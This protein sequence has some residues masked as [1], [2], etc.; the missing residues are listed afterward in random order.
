LSSDFYHVVEPYE[1]TLKQLRTVMEKIQPIINKYW[2]EDKFP[3][4]IIPEL[5]DIIKW[6]AYSTE[7]K[8]L[9]LMEIARIDPS[10]ATFVLVQY[11]LALDS[12]FSLG[13]PKQNEKWLQS[14]SS[15]EKIGCFA[16][17]EPDTG[18]GISKDLQTTAT[19]A[20][21]YYFLNGTKK[22]AGNAVFADLVVVWARD[23]ASDKIKG[24]IVESSLFGFDVQKIENKFGLKI[25]QNGVITLDN[26]KV[27]ES[28]VLEG[29]FKQILKDSRVLVGWLA[30]GV[31][32]GAY[33]LAL[34]YAK[35]RKQFGKPIG[36]FQLIQ[37]LLSK[38]LGNLT[39]CQCMM[40][41]LSKL[42]F[43]TE[44]A[45]LAKSFTTSK[46]RE[47]VAWAREIFGGN[48]LSIDYN[49]G[50]FFADAEAIYSYEGTYQIQNLIV[51]KAITGESAFV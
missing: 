4:E 28:N 21:E 33:E 32:M 17:T 24:F 30:T 25:I 5:K 40:L 36:S 22:W 16:L 37:D 23:I 26:V 51:G 6:V 8:G 29:S 39:A 19:R 2:I 50:R 27:H 41:Q 45:S 35:D 9:Q 48:G 46:M 10:I 13:N 3:F 20:G 18:S 43:S 14:L 49:I 12:I 31:I 1:N 11:G 7:F 34:K 44:Q 42:D 38:I 15:L 47:S